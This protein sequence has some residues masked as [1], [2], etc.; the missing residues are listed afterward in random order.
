MHTSMQTS[1]DD[2]EGEEGELQELAE[3]AAAG[4]AAAAARQ[5]SRVA[6]GANSSCSGSMGAHSGPPQ[7]RLCAGDEGGTGGAGSAALRPASRV[8]T[9][10]GGG[11]C[12]SSHAAAAA[13]ATGSQGGARMHGHGQG[14]EGLGSKAGLP[15]RLADLLA[16]VAELNQVRKRAVLLNKLA[17]WISGTVWNF[18]V[19]T[20]PFW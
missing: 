6:L 15:F 13:A 4:A 3:A 18:V 20:C 11:G 17:C 9:T 12:G 7:E 2:G 14:S 5:Q 1:R 19:V 16:R 10:A 8:T